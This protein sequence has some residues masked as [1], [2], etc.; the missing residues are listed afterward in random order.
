MR[1]PTRPFCST[2]SFEPAE[3]VGEVVCDGADGRS[4]KPLCVRQD[5]GTEAA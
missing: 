2:S 4:I 3:N 1:Q 5:G